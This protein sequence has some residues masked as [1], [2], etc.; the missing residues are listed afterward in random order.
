M[1]RIYFASDTHF[2]HENIIK[3]SNRP[4]KNAT[5]MNEALIANWNSVVSDKDTIYHVGDFAMG[6]R[7]KSIKSIFH[8]LNGHK[9][10]IKGN[11]DYENPAVLELPWESVEDI[12]IVSVGKIKLFLCHYAM[13]T[14]KHSYKDHSWQL[15]GH[16]HA[17]LEETGDL[18]FDVGVDA[19]NYTPISFETIKS[20]IEW[21]LNNSKHFRR[22]RESEIKH[23][24]E[25]G[26]K[27]MN[28]ELNSKFTGL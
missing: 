25:K 2:H 23:S 5:E 17:E 3:Y 8:R 22:P 19:W 14:W 15:H 18:S 24:S 10:L 7:G 12:K 1:A 26:S 9:H 27:E 11:H 21:K 28:R 16:S 13:R 4:F 20:K 6:F